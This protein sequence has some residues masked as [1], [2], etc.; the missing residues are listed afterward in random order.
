MIKTLIA[1]IIITAYSNLPKQTDSTPNITAFNTRVHECSIAVS[2]SL[3]DIGFK[4]GCLVKIS[5]IVSPLVRLDGSDYCG[6]HYIVN[7]RMHWRWKLRADIFYFDN[8]MAIKFGKQ[9]GQIKL[10]NCS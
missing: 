8:D 4:S 3:E 7:D 10:L 5:G 9:K 1:T 2:R 6:G